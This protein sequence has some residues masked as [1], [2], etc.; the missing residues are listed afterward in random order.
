MITVY[1]PIEFIG[2]TFCSGGKLIRCCD[3]QVVGELPPAWNYMDVDGLGVL[4]AGESTVR[5]VFTADVPHPMD[6]RCYQ[7]EPNP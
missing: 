1:V 7:F 6:D 5:Y 3:M 2:S 4:P